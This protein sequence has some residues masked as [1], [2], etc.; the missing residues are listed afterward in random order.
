MC[1]TNLS[2]TSSWG[3]FAQHCGPVTIRILHVSLPRPTRASPF[4]KSPVVMTIEYEKTTIFMS[5]PLPL[6]LH[7]ASARANLQMTSVSECT[8]GQSVNVVLEQPWRAWLG[9]HISTATG[10]MDNVP[11]GWTSLRTDSIVAI[12]SLRAH[13]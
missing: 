6:G 3:F 1:I 2:I 8:H 10:A 9:P 5:A 4:L 12:Y 13:G 7:L 11:E